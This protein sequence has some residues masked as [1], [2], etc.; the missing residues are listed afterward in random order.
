MEEYAAVKV[1]HS[2]LDMLTGYVVNH[3]DYF[4]FLYR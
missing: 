2:P 3:L 1:I 4:Q